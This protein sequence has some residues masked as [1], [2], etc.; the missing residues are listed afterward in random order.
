MCTAPLPVTISLSLSLLKLA[1]D[2]GS[3]LSPDGSGQADSG[4][5]ALS[6]NRGAEAH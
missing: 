6:D 4:H 2:E 5:T 3:S 1:L